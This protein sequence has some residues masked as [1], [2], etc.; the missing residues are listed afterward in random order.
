M[1]PYFDS[2]KNPVINLDVFLSS[3]KTIT[4]FIDTGFSGGCALPEVFFK[5]FSHE[6]IGYQEY[7]LADGSS[8]T[9]PIYITT[10]RFLKTRKQV[11]LFFTKS[12]KGLV[13][14]EFLSH[15]N[16]LFDFQN[17]HIKVM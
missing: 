8:V 3:W 1:N 9:F 2:N 16:W 12:N 7:E 10:I 5:E 13:G 6:S 15:F 14:I 4:C 17:S 11:T